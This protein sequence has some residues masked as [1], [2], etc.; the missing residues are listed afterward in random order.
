MNNEADGSGRRRRALWALGFY[1]VA[2]L[3]VAAPLPAHFFSTV[4]RAVRQDVWLNVWALAWT[5]DHLL[6]APT[7]LFDANIFFPHAH[8]LAYTDHFIGES[9]LVAPLYWLAGAVPAYNLAWY[10]ALILTAWGGFLWVRSLIGDEPAGEAAALVAGAFCLLVPGKRTALSHLQV[11]SLQ[12]VPLALWC[13]H[14][15]WRRPRWR[16]ALALTASSLYAALCSWYTAAYIALVLPAAGLGGLWIEGPALDHGTRRRVLALGVAALSL[17]ALVMVPIALPFRAVQR[18]FSFERPVAELVATSLAPIDFVSSWSWL[19]DGWLPAGSGAG[20]YFPGLLALFLALL[21]VLDGRRRGDRWPAFYAALAAAFALLSLGPR[22]AITDGFSLP[23]PYALLYRFVPGF[24]AL[25]NP[26]RAAFIASLLLAA[27][28]GYGARRVI[29]WG[30]AR[31]LVRQRWAVQPRLGALAPATWAIAVLLST[32]HLLEAWPGPQQ[33][34]LLPTAPSPAYTWLAEQPGAATLVWPLPRPFDDNARY[35]L[36]TVGSWAELVNGHSGLYPPDFVDLYS[37]G[38]EFP[39]PGFIAAL[40]EGFPVTHVLAHYGLAVDGAAAR[41]AAAANPDLQEV[42][43]EGD[44]VIYHL[45]NGGRFGWLRRRLP[46]SMLGSTLRVDA[47]AGARGC[48][49]RVEIDGE[50]AGEARLSGGADA[51]PGFSPAIDLRLPP[52][53]DRAATLAIF[54]VDARGRA[55]FDLHSRLRPEHDATLLVNGAKVL[56]GAAVIARVDADSGGLAFARGTTADTA[57]AGAALRQA[58]DAAAPGDEILVAVA[59]TLDY[60]L[61]ERLR[62]LLEQAGA[63]ESGETLSELATTYAFRGRVGA[64]PGSAIEVLGEESAELLDGDPVGDC[65][66]SPIVRFETPTDRDR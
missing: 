34:E 24:G 66:L 44:D 65:R 4:P 9:L 56:S 61:I 54:L 41:A 6:T 18:E 52:A 60:G 2:T 1:I 14:R 33:V 23:L 32:V 48:G 62:L 16:A 40:K 36:W 47:G 11:I 30:R 3:L 51:V 53:G 17:A 25:R 8:T 7:H 45:E 12:G 58:F 29:L 26:Y 19:H 5:S 39:Q 35:Q 50:F 37:T 21:G 55:R 59:E 43:A 42:W 38:S 63:S 57:A 28:V 64:A 49:L 20:G 27:P 31:L 22:L 10:A 15:L 46:R 13:V